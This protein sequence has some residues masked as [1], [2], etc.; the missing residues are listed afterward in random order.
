MEAADIMVRVA[1]GVRL[2][3]RRWPGDSGRVP[4]LLVHGLSSNARVWD[5]VAVRLAAAHHPVYAVDLRSHGGSDR[6][7]EGY[8]TATAAADLAAVTAGLALPPAIVAGQS[9]GGNVVLAF[10]AAHPERVRALA[11]VDGGWIDL[12]AQFETWEQAEAAL[13]PR[14][15]EGLREADLTAYLRRAHPDWDDWAVRATTA[16]F[17]TGPDGRLA[18]NLPIPQHMLILRSLWDSPPGDVFTSVTA[19]VLL[20]PAVPTDDQEATGKRTLVA[21][22]ASALPSATVR[23]YVGADHDL[24]AQHPARLAK[25]LLTLV[26]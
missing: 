17:K 16:N 18:R 26:P 13:R 4:F 23:E 3:V 12:P 9:W 1:G 21:R 25:D 19:P 15:L 6:P 8:D 22:A 24:H 10:A 2:H 7:A 14:D 20:L 11:L 5:G